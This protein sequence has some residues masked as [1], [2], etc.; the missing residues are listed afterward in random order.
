MLLNV[1]FNESK[2][3]FLI[4]PVWCS[5]FNAGFFKVSP[6]ES[7]AISDWLPMSF[8]RDCRPGLVNFDGS[9][10]FLMESLS[11]DMVLMAVVLVKGTTCAPALAAGTWKK[12][13]WKTKIKNIN[14]LTI[15][16][17]KKDSEVY[18]KDYIENVVELLLY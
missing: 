7:T 2:F 18:T 6:G 12:Y 1:L 11:N 9:E 13:S 5:V 16:I 3:S 8:G 10:G 4:C 14:R 15:F 17:T